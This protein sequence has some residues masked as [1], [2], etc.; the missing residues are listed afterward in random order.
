M[1][2]I[3]EIP[4]EGT[5]QGASEQSDALFLLASRYKLGSIKGELSDTASKLT[6]LSSS[7]YFLY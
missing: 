2:E 7:R 5:S 3:G 4:G 1:F 6:F